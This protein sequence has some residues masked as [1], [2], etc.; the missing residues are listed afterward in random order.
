MT[1]YFC[2]NGLRAVAVHSGGGSSPRAASLEALQAGKIDVV[3]AVDMFNEGVDLPNVDTVMMLRPT[4]STILWMQQFGR[5]LRKAEQ[6]EH[7][8]VID[9]IGNHRIFL[10][11]PR[12][13]LNLAAGDQSIE[14]ALNLLLA[15][16]FTLPPGCEVTY[17]LKTVDILRS[18]LRKP[19]GG[20][21]VEAYYRDFK[22]RQGV[23]PTATEIFHEGFLPRSLRPSHGS[24]LLFVKAMGDLTQPQIKVLEKAGDFLAALEI[25]PMVKSF[26]M[27]TLLSML[28]EN[29]FPGFLSIEALVESFGRQARKSAILRTDVGE[30]LNAPSELTRLLLVNPIAAWTGGRGMNNR[31]YFQYQ[32]GVFSSTLSLEPELKE[33]F[34]ELVR[35]LVDWRLAEYLSRS[36]RANPSEDSFQCKVSHSNVRPILFLPERATHPQIPSGWTE[37]EVE[38]KTYELNFVKV[39]VNVMRRPDSEENILADTLTRWFGPDAGRPGTNR[40]VVFESIDGGWRMRPDRSQ[41]ITAKEPELWRSYMR[42]EIPPLFGLTFSTAIWQTGFVTNGNK[43]FLLVTLD[44]D[45]LTEDHQYEDRFVSAGQFHWKSQNR[46]SQTSKHGRMLSGHLAQGI[47]VHLFVRRSKKISSKAAPFYYCGPVEFEKWQGERP[48]SIDWQLNNSVPDR[49]HKLFRI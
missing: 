24:W 1:D 14:R 19:S 42:E 9:Y 46:T 28:D 17:D 7:L 23:R 29:Q 34:Q 6:K 37:V 44:K 33:P 15:G 8:T 48:I 35:E 20:D 4:E 36:G 39:A 11:K 2:K 41:E 16:G 49:L 18:L 30:A 12:A 3:F 26:K 40:H 13:L 10:N 5:G 45:D 21:A 32:G 47:I 31:V 27:L 25:T 43:I 22:E 38:G